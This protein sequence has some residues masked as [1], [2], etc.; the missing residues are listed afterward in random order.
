MKFTCYGHA[1]IRGTHKHTLEFTKDSELTLRG[2]C[3]VGVDSDFDY[4]ELM[5]F[6]KEYDFIDVDISVNEVKFSFSAEINKEFSHKNEIVFRLSNFVSDRT[7]GIRCDVASVD[8]PS[9]MMDLM[10]DS[11]QKMVVKFVGKK[12]TK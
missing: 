5:K 12:A 3:I 2:D 4:N 10:V 11:E 9:E 1:N 8:I 6:V 7:L